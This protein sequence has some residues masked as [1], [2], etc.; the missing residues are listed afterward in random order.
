MHENQT[1]MRNLVMSD[2][3]STKLAI[4]RYAGKIPPSPSSH[5]EYI[6]MMLPQILILQFSHIGIGIGF[7]YRYRCW[8]WYRWY[9]WQ[10]VG[11]VSGDYREHQVTSS[12]QP[13]PP[14]DQRIL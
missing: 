2:R 8:Y 10:L 14:N 4:K 12:A 1:V 11:S 5:P 3:L 7:G 13:S 9:R 6:W